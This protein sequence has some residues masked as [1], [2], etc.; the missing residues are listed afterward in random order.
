MVPTIPH[1]LEN[2]INGLK[3]KKRKE[4][5]IFLLLQTDITV[6]FPEKAEQEGLED[7]GKWHS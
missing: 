2:K 6:L 4:N 3:M 5:L 7:P 1:D